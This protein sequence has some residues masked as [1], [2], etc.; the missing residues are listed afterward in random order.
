VEYEALLYGL[1]Y[2]IRMGVKD[3]EAY[4]DS[5]LVVNQVKGKNQCLDGILNSYKD[6]CRDFEQLQRQMSRHN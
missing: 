1:E 6:K 4:G 2:L 3:V 5:L